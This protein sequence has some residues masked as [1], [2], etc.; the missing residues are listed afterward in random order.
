MSN[1]ILVNFFFR[2]NIFQPCVD[3]RLEFIKSFW[4]IALWICDKPSYGINI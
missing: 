4:K 2:R 1:H 3:A